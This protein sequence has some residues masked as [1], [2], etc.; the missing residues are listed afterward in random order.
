MQIQRKMTPRER[1]L[2][3]ILSYSGIR[4]RHICAAT[5]ITPP[6]LQYYLQT[7]TPFSDEKIKKV[8]RFVQ[9]RSSRIEQLCSILL[10]KMAEK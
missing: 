9:R 5:K 2:R 6:L 4:L 10:S 1:R 8:L 7:D 3:R